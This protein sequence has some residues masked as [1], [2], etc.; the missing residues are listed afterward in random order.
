HQATPLR[1]FIEF[2]NRA[3]T[4]VLGV[5]G[6]LL[7]VLVWTDLKRSLSYR[8]LGFV[9]IVAVLAQAVIGGVVVLLHLHP[10]WVSLHFGVSAALVAVSL[11]LLHRS[12]EGD[13]A[14]VPAVEP[15][16]RTLA[17]VLYGLTALVVVQIGRASC[18]VSGW[19]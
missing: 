13:G 4:G 19:Q 9:P 7:A 17:W 15:R 16:S 10:G 8:V 5:I 14:P 2:G 12:G 6:I 1:P 18:R 11:L 3:L